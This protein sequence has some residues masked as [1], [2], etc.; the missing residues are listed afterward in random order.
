MLRRIRRLLTHQMFRC[1]VHQQ[2]MTSP[3]RDASLEED[4]ASGASVH[5]LPQ[6]N[7]RV[8][9]ALCAEH[10]SL[11]EKRVYNSGATVKPIITTCTVNGG[12]SHD[13]ELLPQIRMPLM[14]S[15]ANGTPSPEQQ[16]IQQICSLS[17]RIWIKPQQLRH[18]MMS[19]T[20]LGVKRLAH[21]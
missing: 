7:A 12:L 16:R 2:Y 4:A 5:N 14:Q 15:P 9:P 17:L 6:A 18:L 13:H 20:C 21:G 19:E 11:M 1:R 10:D 3:L 8:L